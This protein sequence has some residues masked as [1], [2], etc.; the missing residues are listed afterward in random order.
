MGYVHFGYA[1]SQ[2][3]PRPVPLGRAGGQER[4]KAAAASPGGV[5]LCSNCSHCC[6]KSAVI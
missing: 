6:M 5:E 3:P 1:S 2:D 4:V